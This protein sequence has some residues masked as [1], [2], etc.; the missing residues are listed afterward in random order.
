[1]EQDKP[2]E[3]ICQKCGSPLEISKSNANRGQ[4]KVCRCIRKQYANDWYAR[5]RKQ[6][7]EASKEYYK[8]TRERRLQVA[9]EW[10]DSLSP[11]ERNRYFRTIALKRK[12]NLT[13]GEYE[14]MV[15]LQ[16]GLCFLCGEKPSNGKPLCVDHCHTTKTVRKLLCEVCNR[17]LG[18]IER[19]S[20]WVDRA[21]QYLKS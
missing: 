10:R 2:V 21:L 8:R 14:K 3:G 19:D 6:A 15:D 5:N 9:Q 20:T 18:I 11:T 17:F 7:S 13:L 4:Y 1:M 12:Y 16:N